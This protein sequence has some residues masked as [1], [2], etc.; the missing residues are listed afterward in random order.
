VKA[1]SVSTIRRGKKGSRTTIS[2]VSSELVTL[3]ERYALDSSIAS[4]GMATVWLARDDI[5]ARPVAVKIL[6]PHLSEDAAFVARFRREAL[7]AARLSHPNIVS[8][9]DTGSQTY[10]DGTDRHYIVMEY[11]SGG[12]LAAVIDERGPIEP[13]RAAAVGARIC[14]ALAY[15]HGHGIVHRDIKPANV[16]LVDHGEVKVGDFGI[17]KAAFATSD[18]TATGTIL[19]T[20]TYLSPEQVKGE[21]P[22]ARSDIYSVGILLHELLTGKPP[23]VE[24]TQIATAMAHAR[25]PPPPVRSIRAG[26]PRSLEAVVLKAL[27]KKPDDRF[28]SANE[29]R[30]ALQ[31][32]GGTGSATAV[33][34][35]PEAPPPQ[36][37]PPRERRPRSELRWLIPVLLLV[38][39][40]V[41]A[42]LYLPGLL[43]EGTNTSSGPGNGG[44]GGGTVQVQEVLDFDPDGDGSE[45]PEDAP[46]AADGDPSTAWETENYSTPLQDQ[47]PGVGLV[48]DLGESVDIESVAVQGSPS[49]DFELRASDE[50]GSGFEDFEEV[51]A[52]SGVARETTIETGGTNARYWLVWI[53]NLPGGGPG[54]AAIS[55]VQFVGP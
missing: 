27:A 10:P 41:A 6:H 37:P 21:E 44:E 25:T 8:I 49:M 5:L 55:E 15:A 53:T 48:F 52:A 9:Y 14:E 29:M 34:R 46:S 40:A 19:G 39:A 1:D 3:A 2:A 7:A 24:E 54:T 30:A 47:K 50:Q 26:V 51:D 38:M 12:T 36:A 28:G 22:D 43:D 13:E 16:L 45:H 11:C 31:A 18:I 20:V 23:F 42:A 17:A 4:G 32:A 33:L 35:A